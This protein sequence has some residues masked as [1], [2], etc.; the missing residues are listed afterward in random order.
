MIGAV[1]L[2]GGGGAN[3]TNIDDF[4][5]TGTTDFTTAA[6]A[7]GGVFVR[8]FI[9]S[10]FTT[11]ASTPNTIEGINYDRTNFVQ[12][13]AKLLSN[14]SQIINEDNTFATPS[15][16]LIDVAGA[17]TLGGT[18]LKLEGTTVAGA[19]Y[20]A[21]I[22]LSAGGSTFS[23]NGGITNY[24]IYNTDNP[25]TA[26]AADEMTYQ[27]LMDVITMAVTGSLPATTASASDYD[28]AIA[29]ANTK[30]S[31]SLD[32]AGRLVF[33]DKTAAITQASL[34]VYD[35]SSSTYPATE[36]VTTGAGLMFN[37]NNALTI[38]DPKNDFFNR[39]EEIIQSVEQEKYRAD[40]TDTVDPRNG[41]IQNAIRMIDDLHDHIIR[42]QTEIGSYS[43]L[44][45]NTS[46]RTDM[47]IISAKSLRSEVIDTD[48]AEATLRL[49]QLNLNYQALY[50]S[51]SKVSQLSL[52]NYLS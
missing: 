7:P 6:T 14:I 25:R 5:T 27:Q 1:D 49:Q 50:S 41:G 51:I 3:V 38:R 43:Q 47:L 37:A 31:T 4:Q 21:Q 36:S 30:G 24:T 44:F 18:R 26:V 46:K 17:S 23:L 34:S 39:L 45:D 52:V 40:G 12:E 13:G 28:S 15:T 2:S 19:A 10:G 11:P 8:E 16:K 33:E 29:A 48:M 32:Y 42:T 22:D 20:T 9:H 35:N